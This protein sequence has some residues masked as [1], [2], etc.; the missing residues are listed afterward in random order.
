MT[1]C[2]D[3]VEA[4]PNRPLGS[5]LVYARGRSA[6]FGMPGPVIVGSGYPLGT[7]HTPPSAW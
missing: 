1:Q 3:V 7:R 6:A 4:A 2:V 5:G